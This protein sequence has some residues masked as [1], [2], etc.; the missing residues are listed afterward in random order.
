MVIIVAL[1]LSFAAL[2]LKPFQDKNIEIEKMQNI[3]AAVNITSTPVNAQ[4]LYKKY[5]TE[6]FVINTKGI[7]VEGV[8]AFPIEMKNEVVKPAEKRELPVFVCTLD[9][10]DNIYIV[11]LRGKGLWGPIWGYI[12]LKK[13]M[14]TI[15]GAFFDH[16][17]ETPGLGAEIRESF[18]Q[19]NFINKQIFD[20]TGV[21]KS[22]EVVKGGAQPG[23]LNQVDAIS[24]GTITSKGLEQ[25]VLTGLTDYKTYFENNRQ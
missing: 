21:F 16:Q 17:G 5:I 3:L 25:M 19:K 10:S 2:Q 1:L 7:K 24:G 20:K 6:S 11:P 8:P 14:N 13:D 4:E 23:N 15:H 9:N 22:I 18:F 12:S